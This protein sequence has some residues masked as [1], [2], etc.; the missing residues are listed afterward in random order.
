MKINWHD[1]INIRALKKKND[2]EKRVKDDLERVLKSRI[3]DEK[4]A[5]DMSE[6]GTWARMP[7]PDNNLLETHKPVQASTMR[8]AVSH[9]DL[10]ILVKEDKNAIMLGKYVLE[11]SNFT[12]KPITNSFIV[13]SMSTPGLI[14]RESLRKSLE[15]SSV[16]FDDE[17]KD[18]NGMIPQDQSQQFLPDSVNSAQTASDFLESIS[19]AGDEHDAWNTFF[20]SQYGDV[21]N[22][23]NTKSHNEDLN[24]VKS[25]NLEIIGVGKGLSSLKGSFGDEK[26]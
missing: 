7:V 3:E 15:E 5:K 16:Y 23:D 25:K 6:D 19:Y 24:N 8:T 13:K 17:I 1:T 11:G 9:P 4:K 26:G 20:E 10:D 14:Q 21:S 18:Q 2:F 12:H 22:N